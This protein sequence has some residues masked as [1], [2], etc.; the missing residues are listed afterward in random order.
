MAGRGA[1]LADYKNESKSFNKKNVPEMQ[2]SSPRRR[3]ICCMQR[4]PKAQTEAG[5]AK[6]KD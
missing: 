3:F 1:S 6:L 5:V 4:K 2:I